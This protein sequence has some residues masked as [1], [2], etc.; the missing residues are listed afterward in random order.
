MNKALKF[1]HRLEEGLLITA[2]L[3]MLF[4][5]V[6]Q[7]LLRNGFNS[8]W[9]WADGLVRN[10]LLWT[11]LLGAMIASRKDQHIRIDLLTRYLPQRWQPPL[12]AIVA[13]ATAIISGFCCYASWQ[14]VVLEYQSQTTAFAFVPTWLCAALMPI[15]FAT[16]SLRYLLLGGYQFNR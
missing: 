16:I 10:L 13:F 7:I 5:A 1:I 12:L 9:L 15:A 3:T 2:L 11:A 14:F 8:G 6:G 4:L